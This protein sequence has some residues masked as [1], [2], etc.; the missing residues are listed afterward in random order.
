MAGEV[1]DAQEVWLKKED[2]AKRVHVSTMTIRRAMESGA[3][4]YR[5]LGRGKRG[6]VRIHVDDLDA[7]VESWGSPRD[8]A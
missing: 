3:L 8:E 1:A 4:K 6:I 7:W 5:K 2:A